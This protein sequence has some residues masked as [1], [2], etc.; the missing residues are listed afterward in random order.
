MS[1]DNT[2]A[3]ILLIA[4]VAIISFSTGYLIAVITEKIREL[5][6]LA[7]Q[8]QKDSPYDCVQDDDELSAS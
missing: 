6:E 5:D 2:T 8:L 7:L 4:A 1:I 3:F